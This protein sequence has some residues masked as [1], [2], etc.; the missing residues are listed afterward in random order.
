MYKKILF[1]NL[2][3]FIFIFLLS[4]SFRLSNLDLIEFKADEGINLY[5]AARPF[6]GYPFPPG[7]TVSSVGILNPPIMNYLLLPPLFISLNPMFVSFYIALINCL[8]IGFL[9][10]II[11]RYYNLWIALISTILMA[12]SPWS[13][14]FSRKIW[15]QDFIIPLFIPVFYSLHKIIVDKKQFYYLPLVTFSLFLIQLHQALF[16]FIFPL[17]LFLIIGRHKINF[18]YFLIGTI[19]GIL[20]LIPYIFYQILNGCP[21]CQA[22]LSV[23][24]RLLKNDL[25]LLFLR[26]LQITNSG[27]FYYIMGDDMV[28]FLDRFPLIYKARSL[29]YIEYLLLPLSTLIFFIKFRKLR[30]LTLSSILLPILYFLLKI[31]SLMH[32]FIILIPILFLFLGTGFYYLIKSKNILFKFASTTF[33]ALILMESAGFNFAFFSILKSQ[34]HLKGNYGGTYI[35]SLPNMENKFVKYKKDKKYQEMIMASYMPQDL[36]FGYLPLPK[37]LFK[38]EE[39]ARNLDSLEKRLRDVPEDSLVEDELLAY[40]TPY[41]PDSK[42]IS[43]IKQKLKENTEYEKIYKIAFTNY[44]QKRY[45][46]SFEDGSFGIAFEYPE[47]WKKE[48]N[49]KREVEIKDEKY[50]LNIKEINRVNKQKYKNLKDIALDD[51]KKETCITKDDKWCG[52]TFEPLEINNKIFKIQYTSYMEKP[53]YSKDQE[54]QDRIIVIDTIMKSLRVD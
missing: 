39:T 1:S 47:H 5:L 9:F 33:L 7:A 2:L 34:N 26:P 22:L 17:A 3:L 36:M 11:K 4:A 43:T 14:L 20:P 54:V 42:S 8:S 44:L 25:G 28:T 51:V 29:F 18:K 6:F 12:F 32:Y 41:I 45:L 46:K 23:N 19:I 21:D 48:V 38:R 52:L 40:Y 37:M 30:L 50:V 15:A 24:K 53:L 13:I 16:F 31:D 35:S 10:L 27:D 49:E